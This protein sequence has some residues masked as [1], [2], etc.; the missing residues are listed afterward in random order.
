MKRWS[1]LQQQVIALFDPRLNLQLH[2]RLVRMNTQRGSSNLPRYWLSLNKQTIWAYPDDFALPGGG[3]R[4]YHSAQIRGY[5]HSTDI[6]A[7]SEL[8]RDYIDTPRTELISKHFVADEW[9]LI[10]ILRAADKRI[11]VRHWPL[12]QRKIHNQAAL[13]VLS[14]RHQSQ[15][16]VT[17]ARNKI[18]DKHSDQARKNS[19]L[20][21]MIFS[22][23]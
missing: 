22:Q 10:T 9:G 13:L 21:D 23:T 12:L 3:T 11:G 6:S 19:T 16:D 17:T 1:K 8:L 2:C 4:S 5:P 7:I 20:T 14:E 15:R 18:V